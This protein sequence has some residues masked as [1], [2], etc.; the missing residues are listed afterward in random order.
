MAPIP[1]VSAQKQLRTLIM[2]GA[3]RYKEDTTK[4][5]L[6]T[7]YVVCAYIEYLVQ[8]DAYVFLFTDMLLITRASKKSPNQL[9]ITKAVSDLN[10]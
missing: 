9:V 6:M 10:V 3:L 4:V 1:G 5:S 7:L 8:L 2:E